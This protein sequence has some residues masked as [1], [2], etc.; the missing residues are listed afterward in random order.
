MPEVTSSDVRISYDVVGDGRP[1]MLLHGFAG[2]RTWWTEPGYVADLRIHHRLLIVDFPG[3]GASDHPHEAAAYSTVALIGDVLAVADAEAVDRFAIWGM[4]FG[5]WIAW[6]TAAAVPERIPAIVTSG[7]W[8]PRHDEFTGETDEWADA[9][10]HGGTS[11]LL[12][13][14]KIDMGETFDSEF[15]NWAR[16]I[17]LRADPGALI[18]ARQARRSVMWTS[19]WI[20]EDD[21]R[22]FPVPV[23]LIAGELDDEDD[24]AAW[25]A[26]MVPNA[27]SLRL[28]GVGHPGSCA[29][30]ALTVPAARAFLE[31]WFV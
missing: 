11:A 2:D 7:A 1:L 15:P 14:L 10:R 16:E 23:L 22:T 9:L 21:L 6:M 4:S 18:A 24:D 19:S 29:A 20:P 30:S 8:D 28:P 26:A 12:D 3:H 25:I 27:Q 5:G 17:T 31:R 13:R